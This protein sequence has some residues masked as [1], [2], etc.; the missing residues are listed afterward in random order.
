MNLRL[1]GPTPLPPQVRAALAQPMINHRGPEFA[2]MQ[3]RIVTRLNKF[4]QTQNDILLFTCSG[5]GGMEAA[6]ANT[7]SPGDA[8]L[9][10][11]IGYFGDRF[12]SIAKAFGA[13][14]STLKFAEGTAADPDAVRAKL[15]EHPDARAVF[16][17]HN[18]TST[19]VTNPLGE[20][21]R[22]S[23][24]N[25]DAL[26]VV[27]AISSMGAIDCRVDEWG[28][29]VAVTGAQKVW[30]IPPGLAMIS[31]SARAWE[32]NA[33]ARAPRFYFDFRKAREA[34]AKGQ[35]AFTPGINLYFGLDAALQLMEEEGLA[36]ILARH[37]RIA[38]HT[39][40]GARKLGLELFAADG[41]ASNTV[42]AIK[43]PPGVDGK[44]WRA[45]LRQDY[46]TI[47]AGGQGALTD[48]IQ[49]IGHLGWVTE[50]DIDDCLSAMGEALK[51]V[52]D[53]K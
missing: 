8:V 21:A 26:L 47:I 23:R 51:K 45:V 10:I 27:D 40:A 49:R 22:I 38:A 50:K 12:A 44:K 14:V 32:A 48:K 39:R 28:V 20:I 52:Q 15:R 35:T 3:E 31:V 5:T 7:I 25:S 36:N 17:T 42:T 29:D 4:F 13:E 9:V 11:S 33:Q 53:G 6:V 37:A 24:E 2:A 19:G 41:C 46:D 30:M 43:N 34:Q 16:V 1:V 18:E